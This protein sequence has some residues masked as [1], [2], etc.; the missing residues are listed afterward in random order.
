MK[1]YS[2]IFSVVGAYSDIVKFKYKFNKISFFFDE[3]I[4]NS[5]IKGPEW[6]KLLI[7]HN[8]ILKFISIFK[9][10]KIQFQFFSIFLS[11]K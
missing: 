10:K 3:L 1:N 2:C 7:L 8:N 11:I 5:F 4:L 6:A 9:N